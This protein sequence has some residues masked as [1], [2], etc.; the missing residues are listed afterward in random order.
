MENS[1]Q[2]EVEA[3][4]PAQIKRVCIYGVGGVGGYFGGKLADK[5]KK[6]K[7]A[8]QEIYFIARGEHLNAIRRSGITVITP[9]QTIVGV[10]T[11]ATDD[12]NRIP[13]PDLFLI[14]VKGYDL[15][16]AVRSI[17]PKVNEKTIIM[18]LLNGADIYERI[19][20]NLNKGIVLPACVYVGTHIEKPGFIKQGGGEGIIL[21]G[22]DPRLPEFKAENV[23]R[24]FKQMGMNFK[25][26]DNPFPAVWEKYVFIA[27]FGLV[28][29]YTGKTLGEIINDSEAKK[30]TSSIM[31]EICSIAAKKGVRL[32]ANI[33]EV[34]VNKANNFPYETKTSYQRDVEAKGSV[35]EGDL[36]GGMIIREGEA[37]GVPTPVT[38]S[39][40]SE[41]QRRLN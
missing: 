37:L 34:S 31:S 10:P 1:D 8:N 41:I 28:S 22:K 39:V 4:C 14:C 36:Y 23:I 35:N 19:R 32:S 26:E 38:K 3:L 24:F 25:Y 15:R 20:L 11:L 6:K 29:V 13:N 16:E 2:K 7:D 21:F 30:L 40:Y 27:A 18:P 5:I 33:I 17:E 12:I 9:E